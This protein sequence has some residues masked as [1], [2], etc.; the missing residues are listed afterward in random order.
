MESEVPRARTDVVG[1][2]RYPDRRVRNTCGM[3][4]SVQQERG[5]E[6]AGGET[7]GPIRD[8]A[9]HG[10]RWCSGEMLEKRRRASPEHR[11]DVLPPHRDLLSG[12]PRIGHGIQH[13]LA[14]RETRRTS[15]GQVPAPQ[16]GA[17]NGP[18]NR[19]V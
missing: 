15:F 3:A 16:Q 10:A 13:W 7:L 5:R 17:G 6:V 1:H 2:D 18:T 19:V 9:Q 11:L 14:G 12:I 8:Q 4:D